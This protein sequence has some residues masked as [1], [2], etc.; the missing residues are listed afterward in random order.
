MS[1]TPNTSFFRKLGVAPRLSRTLGLLAWLDNRRPLNVEARAR[2]ETRVLERASPSLGRR[3]P[4]R[5]G[6]NQ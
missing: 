1:A 2:S 3:T 4:H 5:Y 6:L